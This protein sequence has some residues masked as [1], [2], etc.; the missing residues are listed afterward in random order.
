MVKA[1]RFAYEALVGPI[2]KGL[3][4]DHL[5]FVRNCVNPGHMEPVT[6]AVNTLRSTGPTAANAAKDQC[7]NGH[8]FDFTRPDGERGCLR[9]AAEAQARWRE[10]HPERYRAS[11]E[12]QNARR[13]KHVA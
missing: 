7:V 12:R 4:I 2:P 6:S 3:E 9:C 10:R 5:C 1:H 8:P 13:A 11:Y